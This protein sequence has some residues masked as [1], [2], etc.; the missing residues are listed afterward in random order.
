M[1]KRNLHGIADTRA[2]RCLVYVRLPAVT[3][4]IGNALRGAYPARIAELPGEFASLLTR[5]Q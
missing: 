1:E 4:G 3:E 5:L 2:G